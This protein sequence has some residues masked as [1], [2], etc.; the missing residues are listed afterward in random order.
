MNQKTE[1]Y[2][3]QA[4]YAM[5]KVATYYVGV[6]SKKMTPDVGTSITTNYVATGFTLS[7]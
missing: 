2:G 5:N 6:K 4:L 1:S 7:F 3:A